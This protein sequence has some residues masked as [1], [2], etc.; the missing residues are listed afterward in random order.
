M[1]NP[2]P[3]T[4]SSSPGHYAADLATAAYTTGSYQNITVEKIDDYTVK[5]IFKDSN[6]VLGRSLRRLG[7]PDPPEASFWRLYRREIARRAGQSEAGRHR[8]VQVRRVQA[9]RSDPGRTQ[10]RLSRQE[11]AAFR[12][13]RD[14]GRRRRGLR[15]ARRAADRRIRLC[16]EPA[17][18]GR[19]PQADGDRRE[20]QGRVHDLRRCRVH[21]PQHDGPMDRGRRRTVQRQDQ[22]PDAVRSG[23]APGAQPADRPRRRSRNSSTAAAPSQ[24]RASSTSPA[25]SSRAS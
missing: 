2:L 16:L 13:V 12:H 1:A 5:V 15:G 21:H 19:D 25:S 14:Q 7:R 4:M 9:G 22:A 10:P 24:P 3:P 11:P 6:S 18:R 17:G 23:R 20:R 8:P